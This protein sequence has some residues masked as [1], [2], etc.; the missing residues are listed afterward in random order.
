MIGMSLKLSS[1]VRKIGEMSETIFIGGIS[2]LAAVIITVAILMM[3][4]ALGH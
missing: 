4:Q 2:A 1:L 3:N